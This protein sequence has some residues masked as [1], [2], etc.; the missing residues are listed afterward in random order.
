MYNLVN[1]GMF[2]KIVYFFH[3]LSTSKLQ[4]TLGQEASF[5]KAVG[6]ASYTVTTF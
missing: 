3:L 1:V 5:H 4:A 6:C 2:I